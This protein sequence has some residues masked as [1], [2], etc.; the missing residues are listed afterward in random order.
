MS[1]L[2]NLGDDVLNDM[3]NGAD[4]M[5]HAILSIISAIEQA[6]KNALETDLLRQQ[7]SAKENHI[8]F[9]RMNEAEYKVFADSGEMSIQHIP[10]DSLDHIENFSKKV[11]AKYFVIEDANSDMATIC[12]PQKYTQQFNEVIKCTIGEQMKQN[13]NSFVTNMNNRVKAEDISVVDEV[14]DSCMIPVYKFQADDDRINVVPKEFEGQYNSA[15]EMAKELKDKLN[16]VDIDFYNQ[17]SPLDELDYRVKRVSF[18][19]ANEIHKELSDKALFFKDENDNLY[20][21]FSKEH[22]EKVDEIIKNNIESVK[23]SEEY[24]VKIV[25][26]KITMNKS[27][28]EQETETE[29]LFRVPNTSG[30]DYIRIDKSELTNIDNGK[31]FS[32]ALD[33]DKQYQICN[34]DGKTN[35]F[36]SGEELAKNYNT[37]SVL[38]NAHTETSHH[39]NDN[40]ERIELYNANKNTMM[41]IGIRSADEVESV[42]VSNGMSVGAAKKLCEDISKQLPEQYKERFGYAEIEKEFK[43]SDIE[44]KESIIK[45]AELYD[46]IKDAECVLRSDANGEKLFIHDSENNKYMVVGSGNDREEVMDYLREQMGYTNIQAS[47]ISNY[48]MKK[49]TDFIKEPENEVKTFTT[50]NPEVEKIKYI[51]NEHAVVLAKPEIV[52]GKTELSNIAIKNGADRKEIEKALSERLGI[53]DSVSIAECMK[54]LDDNNLIEKAKELNFVA[55]KQEF[56]MTKL[57][58]DYIT[59][60]GTTFPNSVSVESISKS[61]DVDS[62]TAEAIR[63]SID[64]ALDNSKISSLSKLKTVAEKTFKTIEESGKNIIEKTTQTIERMR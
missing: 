4:K 54:C 11:G 7:L 45:Q 12:V 31:T 30:Q 18:A 14:L 16:F 6:R 24:L 41:S 10:K 40:L 13:E 37:K 22:E 36:V 60:N 2:N 33:F 26:N 29:Y 44:N 52:D 27:L 20:C 35:D 5:L 8:A 15:I 56:K 3:V 57:S 19:E 21:K 64:R 62:K 59:I 32:Y 55:D 39:F 42:L 17:T 47:C 63:K 1:G 9:G 25:D 49:N 38:G 43:I 51:A 50:N 58:N 48:A 28:I 61:L 34:K 53:K 23:E 46:K